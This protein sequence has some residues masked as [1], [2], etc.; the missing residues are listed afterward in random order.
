M[1]ESKYSSQLKL[2]RVPPTAPPPLKPSGDS[3]SGAFSAADPAQA[4]E[5]EAELQRRIISSR[6]FERFQIRA[7]TN[8]SAV[9]CFA[10]CERDVMRTREQRITISLSLCLPLACIWLSDEKPIPLPTA[11]SLAADGDKRLFSFL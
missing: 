11:A 2:L 9:S 3:L 10:V 6:A 7:G 5:E 4:E 1:Q 8:Y